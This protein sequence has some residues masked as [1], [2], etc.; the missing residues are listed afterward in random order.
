MDEP[1]ADSSIIPYLLSKMTRAHVK[2]A[3]STETEDWSYLEG[4]Q[5]I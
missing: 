3:L 4:I 5:G 2:V 1:F